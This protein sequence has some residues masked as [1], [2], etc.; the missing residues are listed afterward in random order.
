MTPE[1]HPRVG[2]FTFV[3]GTARPASGAG[4]IAGALLVVSR[5]EFMPGGAFFIFAS[6]ALACLSWEALGDQIALVLQGGLVWYLSHL[7]GSQ[8]NCLADVELDRRE[9]PRLSAAV[10]RIGSGRLGLVIVIESATAVALSAHMA[11]TTGHRALPVLWLTGLALAAGYSLEPLR[12]KR[13]CWL[14]PG[15]LLLVLY[16]LPMT[17]GYVALAPSPEGDAVGV[18]VATGLQML[19]PILLNP[20]EDV[21]SDR[22]QGIKTPIVAY[23]LPVIALL[24]AATYATG[25]VASWWFFGQLADGRPPFALAGLALAGLVQLSVLADLAR[26]ALASREADTATVRRLVAR[27][28]LHFALLGTTLAAAAGLVLT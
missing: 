5:W 9:K 21:D 7:V 26:L 23:G 14:N 13:R 22:A 15:S 8:V 24:A 19:A 4:S 25:T 11:A 2:S 3:A 1:D 20:A 28:P 17:F 10:E 18:L 6:A 16:A 27:N 12:F